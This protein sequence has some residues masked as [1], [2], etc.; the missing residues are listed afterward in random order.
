MLDL[1]LKFVSLVDSEVG[2]SKYG[3]KDMFRGSGAEPSQANSTASRG[4][5]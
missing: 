5:L 1:R 4:L 3:T 2:Q